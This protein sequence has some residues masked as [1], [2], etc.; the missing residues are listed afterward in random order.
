[1][2]VGMGTKPRSIGPPGQ[3]LAMIIKVLRKAAD[4][5]QTFVADAA[6]IPVSTYIK[7][8]NGQSTVDFDNLL[9]IANALGVPVASLV[10]TATVDPDTPLDD[11]TRIELAKRAI[12]LAG[13]EDL[14]YQALIEHLSPKKPN[15]RS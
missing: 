1:M 10:E 6:V 2:V 8:E 12:K 13:S 11:A 3:A 7:M 14:P 4:F 9:R 5:T 15:S